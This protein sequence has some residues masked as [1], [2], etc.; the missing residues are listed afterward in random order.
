MQNKSVKNFFCLSDF[1][2]FMSKSRQILDHFFQLLF[3]KDSK[4]L[5]SLDIGL[6]EVGEKIP[7]NRVRNTDTKKILLSK[8]KFAP[9][10]TFFCATILHPLF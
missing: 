4:N 6:Q 5:T 2:P 10:Q 1:T 9:K 8:E 7:L 3:P